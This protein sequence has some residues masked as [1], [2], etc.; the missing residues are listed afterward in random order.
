MARTQQT[1]KNGNDSPIYVSVEPWPECF[2]LE[3][4]EKLTLIWDA[5]SSGDAI[6][7]GFINE[8][9]LVVWPNGELDDIEFLVN[10]LPGEDRS[11]SF[12][13]R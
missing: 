12:K 9:E 1:F 6:V 4:G 5:P 11:W 2:E 8:R 10:G 7:V 3:P 13:H